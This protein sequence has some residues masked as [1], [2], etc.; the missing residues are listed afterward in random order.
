MIK[1]EL[2][3][4]KSRTPLTREIADARFERCHEGMMMTS[5]YLNKYERENGGV[6]CYMLSEDG[7]VEWSIESPPQHNV[8]FSL[9]YEEELNWFLE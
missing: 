4:I 8:H 5:W 6:L 2:R 7:T 1:F 9:E 3:S